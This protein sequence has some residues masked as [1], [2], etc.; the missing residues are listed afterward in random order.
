MTTRKT[1]LGLLIVLISSISCES[2]KEEDITVNLNYE[3]KRQQ[4]I[5]FRSKMFSSNPYKC[6]RLSRT[7]YLRFY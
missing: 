2:Q 1:I 7:I 4:D 3:Q 6:Q 5:E